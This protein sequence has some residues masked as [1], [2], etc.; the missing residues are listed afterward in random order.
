MNNSTSPN[1]NNRNLQNTRVVPQNAILQRSN[2]GTNPNRLVNSNLQSRSNPRLNSNNNSQATTTALT[3][4]RVQSNSNSVSNL[5]KYSATKSNQ[6]SGQ[7]SQFHQ[8]SYL[9]NANSS[10]SNLIMRN[11]SLP[12]LPLIN[13]D[14]D[15]SKQVLH[16]LTETSEGTNAT[17][18]TPSPASH[19]ISTTVTKQGVPSFTSGLSSPKEPP[20]SNQLSRLFGNKNT[21]EN[22]KPEMKSP[23][24]QSSF[25]GINNQFAG[26]NS[27]QAS[28]NFN[29]M[30]QGK[31]FSN[32]IKPSTG[33][34]QSNK[35]RAGVLNVNRN[36]QPRPQN[37]SI[38]SPKS[39]GVL[40][41]KNVYP[42][43]STGN[44]ASTPTNGYNTA[45]QSY[46]ASL[47]GS[48]NPVLLQALSQNPMYAQMLN[49]NNFSNTTTGNQDQSTAL[50]G[51]SLNKST[52]DTNQM[53]SSGDQQTLNLPN[54]DPTFITKKL[55][56]HIPSDIND[57]HHE[58]QNED[59]PRLQGT[60]I[61]KFDLSQKKSQH[62]QQNS[63]QKS[64]MQ[65]VNVS[66]TPL[67]YEFDDAHKGNFHEI[68]IY[69]NRL[70]LCDSIDLRWKA[71]HFCFM[72]QDYQILGYQIVKMES[73]YR[74][75][76]Q[77]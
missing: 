42:T 54:V 38:S 6:N 28:G 47:G 45:L 64:R 34:P 2:G 30:P 25:K 31:P 75:C 39:T 11:S 19:T 12:G 44:A 63:Q 46:L 49:M 73:L 66:T 14:A 37:F 62:A 77:W 48:P 22:S 67:K 20:S 21:N 53:N 8:E 10:P 72:G 18:H 23:P 57:E 52:F 36:I 15:T 74:K 61:V 3:S 58:K 65:P 51:N 71:D 56:L 69:T 7:K 55:A 13:P 17:L 35:N 33:N 27:K 40:T 41:P 29:K 32:F 60:G 70:G 16:I 5:P 68:L 26:S 50:G 24:P 1:V 9:L 59:S 43:V 76:S 4:A